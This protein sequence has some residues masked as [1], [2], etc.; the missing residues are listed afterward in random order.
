MYCREGLAHHSMYIPIISPCFMMLPSRPV[1]VSE[2]LMHKGAPLAPEEPSEPL[3]EL[4]GRNLVVFL[5]SS[6]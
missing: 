6:S 5:H 2:G 4:G 1:D 3:V